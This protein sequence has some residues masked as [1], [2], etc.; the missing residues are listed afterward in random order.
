MGVIIIGQIIVMVVYVEGCVCLVLDMSGLVQKGGLVMLYVCVV[1][2]LVYIQFICVGI[3]MVDLVI[4]CDVIVIVGCD[5]FL[6]MGEGCIY[7]VV[8]LM[9][10]FI[11]VFVCNLDW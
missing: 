1:E 8:N 10:M 3:G 4:G 6:C 11:V 5:V 7:V 9:Q 2:D